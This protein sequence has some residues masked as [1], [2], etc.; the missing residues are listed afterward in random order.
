MKKIELITLFVFIIVFAIAD[1]FEIGAYFLPQKTQKGEAEKT[2][3][4]ITNENGTGPALSI[5]FEKGGAHNHPLM[6][7]WVEDTSGNYL[8][9]LYVARS[10]ATGVFNFGDA[11]TGEWKQGEIRRP[12][13]LPYWAHKRGVKEEDGL[14][15]PTPKTPVPDAYT[16]A[17]PQNNFVLNT[18]LDK[19]GPQVFDVYLEINQPWDWNEYWTNNKY[20][21]NEDYKASAQPA[22]VYKDR[23]DLRQKIVFF[24]MKP[25]GHSHYSGETGEL[26]T[27]LSTITTA[28]NI[29]E[30]IRV[31]VGN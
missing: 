22:V 7:I 21:D 31:K 12:A 8:Q 28:L 24:E 27:D 15:M 6:A 20:P 13:A 9:T 5:E 4:L 11:S 10:I 30:S 18:R 2:D 3:V 26:F 1:P 16:G 17:T 29:A 23:V 14:Y 25:I 19:P